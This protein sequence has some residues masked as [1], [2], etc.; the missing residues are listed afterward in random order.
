MK[1]LYSLIVACLLTG[2][3][4]AQTST[5]GTT[6]SGIKYGIKAGVN[7]ATVSTSGDEDDD[8]DLKSQTSFL[9]GGL[10]D[11][12]LGTSFSLQPGLILSGKGYKTEYNEEGESE[13]FQRNVMYLEIPV[14][15]V[16]KIG[17]IYLGAGP[18][19]AFAL[20]GKDK[21]K[22]QEEGEPAEE[23]DEKVKFGSGEE[24]MKSSDFGLN[25]LAGYQ[26]TNGFNV[27]L[28]YGLGLSNLSNFDD[29]KVKNRVFSV[30]VGFTF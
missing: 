1:K 12:P 5:S 26:L 4:F 3:A 13:E 11:I 21:W 22:Y 9:I 2:V 6:K 30:T 29:Y 23:G 17:G 25:I 14:N 15:A 18:Y 24:E 28:N 7:F 19:A 27:G 16:Y 8:E 10:V 20:S